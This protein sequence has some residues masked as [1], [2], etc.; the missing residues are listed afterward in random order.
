[1]SCRCLR[2]KLKEGFNDDRQASEEEGEERRGMS[3]TPMKRWKRTMTK[4]E[5]DDEEVEDAKEKVEDN[6]EEVE[7]NNRGGGC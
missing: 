5:N 2:E 7:E 3:R 1:M 6:D 4:K